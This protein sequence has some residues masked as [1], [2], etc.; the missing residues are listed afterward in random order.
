MKKFV[1]II[2]ILVSLFLISSS[3]AN[4]FYHKT[5]VVVEINFDE[6]GNV[7]IAT[8][9]GEGNIWDIYWNLEEEEI[10]LGDIISMLIWD[11]GTPNNIFD[12]EVI[13]AVYSGY[14]IKY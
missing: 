6:H 10:K 12:D 14:N 9:D 4:E 5:T 2:I 3:I 13:D 7:V 1:T 11:A 8:E